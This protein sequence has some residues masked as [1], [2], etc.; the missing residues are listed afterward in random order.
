MSDFDQRKP[1]ATRRG[2]Q[3]KATSK[4]QTTRTPSEQAA[5]EAEKKRV[6]SARQY[7][8]DTAS[9]LRA[10]AFVTQW[11][12]PISG[13][14]PFG[15]FSIAQLVT[16][17][18]ATKLTSHLSAT[19]LARAHSTINA[20]AVQKLAS[21][22]KADNAFKSM[23]ALRT[24]GEPAISDIV[25]LHLRAQHAGEGLTLL[26][27]HAQQQERARHPHCTAVRELPATASLLEIV[28]TASLLE[29]RRFERHKLQNF[30][31]AMGPACRHPLGFGVGF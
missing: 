21:M 27:N 18:F 17:E 10:I 31:A 4:S 24:S 14:G 2:Q 8:I 20:A 30:P 1:A 9:K 25:T 29:K 13:S 26:L 23:Q 28:R 22:V 11:T 19:T 16:I 12:Q 7:A 15:V 5:Y 3:S 6:R